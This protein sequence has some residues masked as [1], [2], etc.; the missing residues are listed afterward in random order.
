[1]PLATLTSKTPI[2]NNPSMY[3]L[4][5]STT[6]A[7]QTPA[8][9]TVFIF[10]SN[11]AYSSKTSCSSGE[12]DGSS[13]SA[14]FAVTADGGGDVLAIFSLKQRV[15]ATI[16]QRRPNRPMSIWFSFLADVSVSAPGGGLSQINPAKAT[17]AKKKGSGVCVGREAWP[18]R[19]VKTRL[20]PTHKKT[21]VGR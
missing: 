13:P 21:R 2:H 1:M 14:W 4:E 16:R 19:T 12:S 5:K 11:R 15:A 9:L 8:Q 10:P 3:K 7:K 20:Y 6:T 18:P 17:L